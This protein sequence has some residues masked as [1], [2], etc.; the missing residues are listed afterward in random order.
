[1]WYLTLC[2]RVYTSE[3]KGA[4]TLTSKLGHCEI[5]AF[6]AE[7]ASQKAVKKLSRT[8]PEALGKLSVK[9]TEQMK[10]GECYFF[11]S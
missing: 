5:T 6:Q 10:V 9:G 2:N 8:Q 4:R 1:M 3:P 11:L 7:A